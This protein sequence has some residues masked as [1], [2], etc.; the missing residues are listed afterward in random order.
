VVFLIYGGLVYEFSRRGYFARLLRHR[1]E[2]VTEVWARLERHA[3]PVTILG[4]SYKEDARVGRAALLSA[5]LQY[6]PNPRVLLLIDHPPSPTDDEDRQRLDESRALPGDIMALLAPLRL[7]FEA[8]RRSAE[9]R[10]ANA[11]PG[12]RA[13]EASTLVR[14]Y[15]EAARWFEAQAD[16]HPV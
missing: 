14:L 1:P 3:P 15:D 2:P 12:R 9:A 13:V 5:A 16:G 4:P 6:Y 7:R 11:E 8:E 10:M